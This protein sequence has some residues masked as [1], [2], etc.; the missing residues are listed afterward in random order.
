MHAQDVEHRGYRLTTRGA[1]VSTSAALRPIV[2][3]VERWIVIEG[4]RRSR[5]CGR[6][7][8]H[9]AITEHAL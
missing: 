8:L 6:D 3:A 7:P 2:S 1:A 5:L 9:L 4:A